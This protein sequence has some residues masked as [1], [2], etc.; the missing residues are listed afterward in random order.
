MPKTAITTEDAPKP[1]AT[2]NQAVRVGNILQVAGQGP[3]DPTSGKL[4]GETVQEQTEQTLQ[5]VGAILRAA[6]A[7]FDDVVMMRVYLTR[8]D[9]F[10]GMNEIYARYVTDPFPARTTVFT[11][12]G[13]GMLVEIDALA[14]LEDD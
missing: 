11:G 10:R 14:V 13:A 7:S 1:A 4:V 2:Y 8:N 6:G 12:L 5:N 9:D 3:G